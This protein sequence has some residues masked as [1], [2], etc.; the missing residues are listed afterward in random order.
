MSNKRE[1]LAEMVRR[2]KRDADKIETLLKRSKRKPK[3]EPED[4]DEDD[5]ND[6]WL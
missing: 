4:D 5:D 1:A 3:E 2:L 6:D